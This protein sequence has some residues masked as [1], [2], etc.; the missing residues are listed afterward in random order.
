M[1]GADARYAERKCGK[2]K[3]EMLEF[4]IM[5]KDK[6]WIWQRNTP[7]SG[8]ADLT[9]WAIKAAMK[10]VCVCVCVLHCQIKKKFTET[11]L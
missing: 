10:S 3:G 11:K 5:W 4:S 1:E 6:L 9:V 8:V 7:A 2:I